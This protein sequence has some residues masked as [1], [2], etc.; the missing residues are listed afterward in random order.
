MSFTAALEAATALAS[1]WT[2]LDS[3][4]S[5]MACAADHDPSWGPSADAELGEKE[6]RRREVE[7]LLGSAFVTLAFEY[8]ADW[9]SYLVTATARL[10]ALATQPKV[11]AEY[12]RDQWTKWTRGRLE[13]PDQPVIFARGAHLLHKHE[14]LIDRLLA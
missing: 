10:T 9:Q 2:A 7:R 14:L 13:K 5:A 6:A 11:Y 8:P 4:I 3:T 12:E 1:E